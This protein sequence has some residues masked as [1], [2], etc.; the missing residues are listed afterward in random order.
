MLAV[1][2]LEKMT[3]GFQTCSCWRQITFLTKSADSA[4]RRWWRCLST[5]KTSKI[6]CGCLWSALS[7]ADLN[8]SQMWHQSSSFREPSWKFRIQ[9]SSSDNM[10]RLDQ[11]AEFVE[12]TFGWWSSRMC[13]KQRTGRISTAAWR[14]LGTSSDQKSPDRAR[15]SV[16]AG[17]TSGMEMFWLLQLEEMSF[18]EGLSSSIF[19][20]PFTPAGS[21]RLQAALALNI[22]WDS[23]CSAQETSNTTMLLFIFW[24]FFIHKMQK[25]RR[26]WIVGK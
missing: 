12:A 6:L 17:R 23:G 18:W 22:R 13:V 5:D 14:D 24:L 16:N 9:S 2:F 3:V 25:N 11:S 21:E 20:S 26:K 10:W 15:C 8:M 7:A 19:S 1:L 4:S